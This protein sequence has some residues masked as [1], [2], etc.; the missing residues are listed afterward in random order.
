MLFENVTFISYMGGAVLFSALFVISAYLILRA[1]LS[2]A[3]AIASLFSA[4]WCGLLGF[5]AINQEI[6]VRQL[7]ILETVHVGCWVT[8]ALQQLRFNSKVR[9][10]RGPFLILN[11]LW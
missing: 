4:I 9:G 7:L 6:S 11:T 3:V 2:F 8:A 5:D 10:I 1:Q